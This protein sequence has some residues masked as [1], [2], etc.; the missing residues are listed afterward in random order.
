M[1][2]E[3]VELAFKGVVTTATLLFLY[4]IYNAFVAAL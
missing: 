3:A 4:G 2:K 1:D